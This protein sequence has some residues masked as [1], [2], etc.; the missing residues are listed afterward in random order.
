MK[1]TL[2]CPKVSGNRDHPD[3]EVDGGGRMEDFTAS[4][5]QLDLQ[6]IFL[7]NH[8]QQKDVDRILLEMQVSNLNRK[9]KVIITSSKNYS[10]NINILSDLAEK[11]ESYL[12]AIKYLESSPR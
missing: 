7:V 3:E 12:A 10:V 1:L 6:S 8:S 2:D 5:H 11:F 4:S 9:Q